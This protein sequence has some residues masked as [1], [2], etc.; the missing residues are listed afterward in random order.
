MSTSDDFPEISLY[1]LDKYFREH[2]L[3]LLLSKSFGEKPSRASL[4]LNCV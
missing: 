3:P 2:G 1:I 4:V